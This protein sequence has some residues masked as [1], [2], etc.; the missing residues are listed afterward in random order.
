M[1]ERIERIRK[2][3]RAV[4]DAALESGYGRIVKSSNRLISDMS[5]QSFYLVVC[6]EFKRGKS[7]F[8]NSLLEKPNLLPTDVVPTTAAIH[9]IKFGDEPRFRIVPIDGEA[10]E[11]EILSPRA[12]HPYSA[13]PSGGTENREI[14]AYLDIRYPHEL[15]KSGLV[16]VDTPGVN[17]LNTSRMEIT[18]GFLPRADA[19]VFLLDATQPV[20]KS[21]KLFLE[22]KLFKS[23]RPYLLFLLNKFDLLD[24]AEKEDSLGAANERLKGVL[25]EQPLVLPCVATS[26][27]APELIQAKTR[28]SELVN[29]PDRELMQ[30]SRFVRCACGVIGDFKSEL[31]MHAALMGATLNEL[32]AERNRLE[33]EDSN[34]KRDISRFADYI[35]VN[36]YEKLKTMLVQSLDIAGQQAT[37]DLLARV[38]SVGQVSVY[39]ENSLAHDVELA[40]RRWLESKLPEIST[41]I[42]RFIA[43][44]TY[45]YE[46]NF[47]RNIKPQIARAHF[48]IYA[49][50][51]EMAL[52]QPAKLLGVSDE[53]DTIGR[54]AM[55]VTG[56]LLAGLIFS[57]GM[58]VLG[59]AGGMFLHHVSQKA[60]HEAALAELKGMIPGIVGDSFGAM[61]QHLETAVEHWFMNLAKAITEDASERL[62][63][64]KERIN[65]TIDGLSKSSAARVEFEQKHVELVKFLNQAEMNLRSMSR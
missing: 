25:G 48:G 30:V 24:E 62:R 17:D 38:G 46:T 9:I 7:T 8:I 19:A 43:A 13:E 40:Q 1:S 33:S 63:E 60:K 53:E 15:L 59:M 29:S 32:E 4:H 45:E 61:R 18:Y 34:F 12:L 64:Y 44:V 22:E 16:I 56:A 10:G 58:A 47:L 21:E 39:V 42:E 65:A 20:S 54:F 52:S 41:F 28:L 51:R 23:P 27:G 31:D 2:E 5:E 26:P 3:W 37:H 6:G 14:L 49:D 57:G 11:W 55:P 36:G 50:G 35:K